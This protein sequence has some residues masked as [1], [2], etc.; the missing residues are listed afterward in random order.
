MDSKRHS[1]NRQSYQEARKPVYVLSEQHENISSD[2]EEFM[3]TE[4]VDATDSMQ[5]PIQKPPQCEWDFL[6]D[7]SLDSAE[8][9]SDAFVN[10]LL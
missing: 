2:E 4:T 7:I 3:F 9:S 10:D 5:D 1:V 6:E 8:M